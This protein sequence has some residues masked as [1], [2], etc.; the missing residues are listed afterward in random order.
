MVVGVVL[1]VER[2][3]A[4]PVGVALVGGL[5]GYL[6]AV[7]ALSA[8][9]A[10][11]VAKRTV[12]HLVTVGV[13]VA[14]GCLLIAGL[15]V[16]VG[17][18]RHDARA[19]SEMRCNGFAELCDRRLDQ[20]AF[21]GVH[22]AM[23]AASSPGWLFA[24]NVDGIP[25]QLAAGVRAL[26]VKTHY[27]IQ[28][29]VSIGAAPLV[30]T[31]KAAELAASAPAE[32]EELQPAAIAR[33]EQLEKTAPAAASEHGVYLCHVY[34]S[35]GATKFSTVLDELRTFL[36]RNPHDVVM[37]FIGDYISPADTAKE[38]EQAHLVDRIWQYDTTKPPPTLR[39]M[40]DAGRN[41]LVLSEH[42]GGDPPWYTKGYGIFQDTPFTFAAQSDFSCAANRGPA[43]AP[44]FQINHWITN[45]QPPSLEEAKVV[46]SYDVLHG[47]VQE[48]MK[49][50]G[51][52]P[53]IV[54]VNFW[55]TGDLFKVVDKLNGV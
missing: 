39:Q 53:T 36:V 47:R 35:L 20:V 33:A 32:T 29:G 27:G 1:V 55:E 7:F 23:S 2:A 28:T 6:G 10:R 49:E 11:A 45:K 51:K 24:E 15:T 9:G 4:V 26:L 30:V 41:L 5:I 44:L 31:D 37:L 21:A 14:V 19:A 22:N 50:R 43:N 3:V 18:A 46:N 13:V 8:V 40:I 12:H 42:N 25:A 54:G 52:F 38:F 34:C 17:G 48:C 16:A